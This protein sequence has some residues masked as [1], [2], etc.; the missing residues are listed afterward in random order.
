M[1]IDNPA[2][3]ARTAVAALA[4]AALVAG[5][6][7][8]PRRGG[9]YQDDGPGGAPPVDIDRI[10]DARPRY[11]PLNPRANEPYAVFGLR[12]APYRSLHPYRQQ[13]GRA[14]V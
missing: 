4:L 2:L 10:A 3:P 9:Y 11:E 6:G 1:K 7:S 14:H 8:E 5:C 13:I 12:Y